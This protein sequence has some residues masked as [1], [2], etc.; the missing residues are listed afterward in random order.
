[1]CRK[2]ATTGIT[3]TADEE[4]EVK[5]SDPN[6]FAVYYTGNIG[7]QYHYNLTAI[8]DM[9]QHAT[10]IVNGQE[11]DIDLNIAT[12]NNTTSDGYTITNPGNN[13][14]GNMTVVAKGNFGEITIGLKSSNEQITVGTTNSDA[15]RTTW[16]GTGADGM[17]K[18]Y[19]IEAIRQ[20]RRDGKPRH[21]RRRPRAAVP[22]RL[23]LQQ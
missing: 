15:F 8:G 6:V 14:S 22:G 19:H 9:N 12:N 4:P 13:N 7:K 21:Q 23:P 2:T 3:L 11:T 10:V 16:V 20:L 5:V 18:T 1:M 17:S